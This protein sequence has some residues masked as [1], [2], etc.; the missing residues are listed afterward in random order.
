MS[1]VLPDSWVGAGA[2][3]GMDSDNIDIVFLGEL[4]DLS[5]ELVPDTEG[6]GGATDVL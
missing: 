3:M 6:G 5:L 4:L 2:D 1:D